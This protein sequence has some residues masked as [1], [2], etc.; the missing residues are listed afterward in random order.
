MCRLRGSFPRG[1]EWVFNHRFLRIFASAFLR[2]PSLKILSPKLQNIDQ[3]WVD[4]VPTARS[5]ALDRQLRLHD[6]SRLIPTCAYR[7]ATLLPLVADG[8]STSTL[9]QH[10]FNQVTCLAQ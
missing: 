9:Y 8:G 2:R 3:S 4:I 6:G 10:H 5:Y 7:F 1:L